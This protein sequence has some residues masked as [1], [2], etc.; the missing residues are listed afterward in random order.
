MNEPQGPILVVE[1]VQ[2]IR[3]LLQVTLNFRGYSVVTAVDGLDAL[4]K[5]EAKRPSLIISDLLMPNLDGFNLTQRIRANPETRDI[6]IILISAT[7]L[8]PEDKNFAER[9]GALRFLEKPVDTQAF[10]QTVAEV[11]SQDL[12]PQLPSPL[13]SDE[14]YAEY[15]TRLESKMGH[16][17]RQIKRTEQLL[18]NVS[19]AEKITFTALLKDEMRQYSQIKEE[20]DQI[21][22][23]LDENKENSGTN[24]N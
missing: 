7:Y 19:G 2:N 6:P 18:E 20:L 11:L 8:A 13:S 4:E 24:D 14:F 10:L 12:P 15:R 9:L 21:Y 23:I 16:K 22:K 3:D 5:I 17:N 1:D